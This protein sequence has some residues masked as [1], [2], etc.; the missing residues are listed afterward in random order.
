MQA[1][2]VLGGEPSSA[3]SGLALVTHSQGDR[4]CSG[5]LLAPEL[6]L[7]AKHCVFRRGASGDE[8]LPAVGFR[9]GFGPSDEE[10][11]T[12]TV[13]SLAWIGMPEATSIDDAVAAGEDV[14]VLSLMEPAPAEETV[15]DLALVF[16]PEDQQPVRFA[17]YG[18]S[19]VATGRGGVRAAGAGRITGFDAPSGIVQIEGDAACFGDSGGPL[20]SEGTA[21]DPGVVLGVLGQ[22]GSIASPCDA[23]ASFAATAANPAVRRFLSKQCAA[24]GRCGRAPAGLDD[25]G[26]T[27]ADA[28]GDADLPL[29]AA[30]LEDPAMDA[31]GGRV[32]RRPGR[33]LEPGAGGRD[34]GCAV[35]RI[36]GPQP[37]PHWLAWLLGVVVVRRRRAA[38]AR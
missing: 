38:R 25:G 18:L 14:A 33:A 24:V 19:D 16:A 1:A 27:D 12:R 11:T 34:D 35:A 17:G 20:L 9:V 26:A 4:A 37:T 6:V 22:V 13:R 28:S 31:D 15:R 2:A 3:L 30:P 23:A 5:V 8:P 36:A 21:D 32:V 7:T 10:L 29:D